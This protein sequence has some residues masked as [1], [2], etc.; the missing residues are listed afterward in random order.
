MV[1]IIYL[2]LAIGVPVLIFTKILSDWF[3][4]SIV[5]LFLG[6]VAASILLSRTLARFFISVDLV[7]AFITTDLLRTFMFRGS[8]REKPDPK[9]YE[10]KSEAERARDRKSFPT[11]GPGLHVAYPW[12]DRDR[13]NN[14]SLKEVNVDFDFPV[15]LADGLLRAK[16][17]YRLRP[18]LRNLIPF[19]SGVATIPGEM[20]DLI[21]SF[22]VQKLSAKT[23][24]EALNMVG[25]LND[26]LNEK[27]GLRTKVNADETPDDKVSNF[28]RRFGV[29]VGDVTIAKLLPTEEMQRTRGAIDEARAIARGT[30]IVLGF[31]DAAEM[32]QAQRDGKISEEIISR[33]R[34]R[35]LSIS[36]NLEGMDISRYEIDFNI[37]GLDPEVAKALSSAAAAYAGAQR[38]APKGR[39]APNRKQSE[40]GLNND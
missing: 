30:A 19:L 21:I 18:D 29:Y 40:K 35:F 36:G 15:Q 31:E 16:G 33:G 37:T 20:E 2:L 17:S 23:A 32:R 24:D 9:E 11:Y 5:G 10:Q 27:F 8:D 39:R 4:L 1:L 14:F 26:D 3:D 6:L 7:S 12:E 34:D 13:E 22:A 38:R 25:E 28:E